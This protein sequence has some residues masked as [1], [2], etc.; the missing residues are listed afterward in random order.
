MIFSAGL[1]FLALVA[2]AEVSSAQ[3]APTPEVPVS[4]VVVGRAVLQFAD[5]SS[6]VVFVVR[7]VD[8][9]DRPID[10]AYIALGAPGT[11]VRARP[12]RTLNTRPEGTA[13]LVRVDS[14]DLEA[15]VLRV[16]YAPM[17]FTLRLARR[18][19]QTVEVYLSKDIRFPETRSPPAT[20]ARVVLTTCAPP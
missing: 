9:P 2:L 15:V 14:A 4:I 6:D 18:C 5:T 10:A 16:G 7:D 8:T 17:R 11:D 3:S 19:R 12:A 20:P 13:R 1:P